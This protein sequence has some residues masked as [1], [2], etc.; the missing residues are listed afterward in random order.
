MC[1]TC[2]ILD[3]NKQINK[4]FLFLLMA[5]HHHPWSLSL[6]WRWQPLG[7]RSCERDL[8]GGLGQTC[9]RPT[10]RCCCSSSTFSSGARSLVNSL[11]I[12]GSPGKCLQIQASLL[13]SLPPSFRGCGR[14]LLHSEPTYPLTKE[15]TEIKSPYGLEQRGTLILC[16][17]IKF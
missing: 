14:I 5:F 11:P 13:H 17:L 7:F 2:N 10:A 1:H 16:K 15:W 8:P 3:R 12:Q 4:K 9:P 6:L